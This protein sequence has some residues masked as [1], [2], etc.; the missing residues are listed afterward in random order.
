VPI[1]A[2]PV[3]GE[4]D[5]LSGGR[6]GEVITIICGVCDAVWER[7]TVPTCRLCGSTDLQGVLTSTL[8]EHGRGDQWAP[9]GI[10]VTYFCWG[11]TGHDVTSSDPKPPPNP[12]P[13]AH[14]DLR[15]LR[16]RGT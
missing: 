7:D 13:G 9:S 8:P 2:C 15:T 4:D 1:V 5:D 3:C 11:C 12:P 10:R 14:E 6:D 16:Q